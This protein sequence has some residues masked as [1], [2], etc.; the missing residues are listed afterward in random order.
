R[1]AVVLV[2]I[3]A[4]ASIPVLWKMLPYN[5]LPEED[6]SQFQ[7]SLEAPRGTSLNVTRTMA[8][9][10]DAQIRKVPEVSYTLRTVGGWS[11]SANTGEIYVGLKSVDDRKA[12]QAE[13]IARMRRQVG[14]LG[15]RQGMEAR[16]SPINTFSI[17]G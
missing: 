17:L 15:R 1:W 4:L 7:I 6:E 8:K 16:V 11:G 3:G 9:K 13:I 14:L 2:C 12:T 10:I 5:F